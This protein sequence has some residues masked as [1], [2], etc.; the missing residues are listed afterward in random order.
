MGI[1]RRRFLAGSGLLAVCGCSGALG[2]AFAADKAGLPKFKIRR[3]TS[4]PK[5]HFFGYYG[6]CP[7]NKS[8]RRMVCL[9]SDFQ[10][11]FPA[12]DEPAVIG[13]VDCE[14]GKFSRISQTN[15]WNLQ[16]GAMLHWN[17]L[18]P[19]TEIIYND[20]RNNEIVSVILDV[21]SGKRRVLDRAVSAV[22][23]N[24]RY[25]LSLTYGRLARLRKTVGY[26]GT[27]DPNPSSPAPDND[28]VFLTDLV[29]GKSKLVVSIEK[30]Q[31]MLVENHPELQ[32][33]HIW[34]NHTVFNRT[35]TRFFFLARSK[36]SSGGLQTGMF[37]ANLDGS[38]LREV[39]PY[40]SRVS[41]FDWRNDKQI[42]ATFNY[43]GGGRKHML[44]TDGKKDFQIVGEGFL[45][46]DGH[47]TFSPDQQ[48]LA[49]DQRVSGTL[50]KSLVIFN[51]KTRQGL[52][53]GKF[54]MLEKRYLS[55]DLRCDLHPRWNRIGDAICIDAIDR[56]TGTRQLHIAQLDFV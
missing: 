13:L 31:R 7:W 32:S 27:T 25:A 44:F 30:V 40:G 36:E 22:S 10:D 50:A 29:S 21:N 3:L 12:P 8:Q 43:E 18:E 56:A 48:W 14:T 51:V 35:D 4:G 34:F 54:D 45:H 19:E 15:A 26:L 52:V 46:G 24:G 2:R 49:T 1:N 37:T 53:L 42:I 23:N 28:G 38:E 11:H 5:H 55:G 9:Q 33:R 39:V 47:C 6:I 20:R 16:Q 41:H 17:P